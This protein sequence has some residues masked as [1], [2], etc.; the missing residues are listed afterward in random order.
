MSLR[1]DTTQLIAGSLVASLYPGLGIRGDAVPSTGTHGPGLLFNDISLPGEAADE[2]MCRIVT[3]P[4]GTL[5]LYEDS[6]FAYTGAGGS[7]TYQGLKNGVSYGTGAFTIF[8]GTAPAISTQPAAQTVTVGAVATFS[9]TASGT[10]PLSYQ[11]RFNG[12]P[13]SGATSS[14]YA[15]TTVIGDNGGLVS[16]VVT[17][18]GGSV[19]S[20]NAALT[21]NAAATGPV[22]VTQPAAQTVDEGTGVTFTVAYTGAAP[23]ALQWMRNGDDIS[24]ETGGSLAFVAMLTDGGASFSVRLT[25]ASGT[26]TSASALLTVNSVGGTLIVE[27]GTAKTDSDSYISTVSANVYHAN[28]GNTAWA[29]LNTLGKESALRKATDYMAQVYRWRWAGVRKT[30]TQAL[31]WPRSNVPI[32]DSPGTY[33]SLSAYYDESSVP[34]AVQNACAELA[35]RAAAGDLAPDVGRL[36]SKEKIDVIEVEFAAGASPWVRYRAIDNM[37]TAYFAPSSGTMITLTRG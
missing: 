16:V 1:A 3:A 22:I 12:T 36:T 15:R 24:G 10:A 8:I 34:T 33:G 11:W 37:L 28:R 6:S 30:S 18:G 19:T 35:L 2:F 29:A 20:S 14:S 32:P 13:V 17:N 23:V 26:V 25:N 5:T 9:V 31:D 4:A 27:D 21:V 7:G